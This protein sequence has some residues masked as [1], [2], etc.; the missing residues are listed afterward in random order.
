MTGL[1]TRIKTRWF[2]ALVPYRASEAVFSQLFPLFVRQGLEYQAGIVGV[3]TAL[4]SLM[5]VPGSMIWGALSDQHRQRRLFLLLGCLG[6]SAGLLGMALASTLPQM[7][8]LCLVYGAFSIA[9]GPIP[10]IL[11]METTRRDHWEEALGTFNKIGGWGWVMGLAV[12]AG[13]LSLLSFWLPTT[14]SMRLVLLM[15]AAT[16]LVS[17]WWIW[18]TVPEPIHRVSRSQYIQETGRLPASTLIER[19]L[20]LPR[21]LLFVLHPSELRRPHQIVQPSLRGYFL[22]TAMNFLSSTI[23]FTPLPLFLRDSLHMDTSFVFGL[24]LV[25]MLASTVCYEWAA[26]WVHRI[27]P[28][29]SQLWALVGRCIAFLG[30]WSLWLIP[31]PTIALGVLLGMNWLSGMTW[32]FIAVSGPVLV[33]HLS[34]PERQGEAMGTYNAIQGLS[35]I[36]GAVVSGYLVQ[37]LG[38]YNTFAITG[39]LLAVAIGLLM[40]LRLPTSPVSPLQQHAD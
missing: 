31:Q 12:G 33:G 39:G 10:S 24:A 9:L 23:I 11:I 32:S 30:F 34:L 26:T 28:K 37:W 1:F 22:V 25:R 16:A 13:L 2:Y 29:T 5:A 15:L 17:A 18:H 36:I 20:Y 21:L 14:L 38:Y 35:R 40:Q 3:L 6:S 7:I 27:G 19:V 8:L 4:I